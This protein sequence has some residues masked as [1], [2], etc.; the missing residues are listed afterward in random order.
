MAMSRRQERVAGIIKKVASQVILYE[1]ADPRIGLVT[2]TRVEPSRDNRY[3]KVY[4]SVMGSKT[5]INKTM[6]AVRSARPVIQ[7][8]LG[9]NLNTRFTPVLTFIEDPSIKNS[10]RISQLIKKALEE[11]KSAESQEG[12]SEEAGCA[13]N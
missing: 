3:A 5:D 4:I 8:E 13:D 9:K 6:A 1:L 2:V 10:I 7:A 11:D 12:G